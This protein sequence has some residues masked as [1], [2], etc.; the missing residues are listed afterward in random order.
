MRTLRSLPSELRTMI[1]PPS[2]LVMVSGLSSVRVLTSSPSVIV[3]TI[4]VFVPSLV[5]TTI[6][7]PITTF[8]F[9]AFSAA[10]AF[11]A[12]LAFSF[13]FSWTTAFS[14]FVSC[15]VGA[16]GKA[17]STAA[18]TGAAVWTTVAVA[19]FFSMPA[20]GRAVPTRATARTTAEA[21]MILVFILTSLNVSFCLRMAVRRSWNDD[22]PS[23]PSRAAEGF[24]RNPAERRKA[25]RLAAYIDGLIPARR[26]SSSQAISCS[27][28]S[29]R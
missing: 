27:L 23:I 24:Q 13:S 5:V 19:A 10:L 3:I 6:F 16:S 14:A 21:S 25:R 17:M 4:G 29:S 9:S 20:A 7:F 28:R 22:L 11:A 26:T 2:L 18:A 15:W 1:W 12:A 8:S